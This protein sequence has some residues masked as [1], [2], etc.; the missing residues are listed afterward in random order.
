[1]AFVERILAAEFYATSGRNDLERAGG[2]KLLREARQCGWI[3]DA[4]FDQLDRVRQLRH[5]MV[6]FRRPIGAETVERR[7]GQQECHQEQIIE[8]DARGIL[9]AVF[10]ILA[11]KAIGN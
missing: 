8:D 5:S 3:T 1:M 11:K 6:H 9:A 7:A 10:G 2:Q 4:E